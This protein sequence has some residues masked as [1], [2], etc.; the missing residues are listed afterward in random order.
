M[1]GDTVILV[2]GSYRRSTFRQIYRYIGIYPYHVLAGGLPDIEWLTT[3]VL[4]DYIGVFYDPPRWTVFYFKN[5][6]DAFSFKLR[7]F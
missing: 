1:I 4:D 5:E 3:N 6:E 7:Y 2:N